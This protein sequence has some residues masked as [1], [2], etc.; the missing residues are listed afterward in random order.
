V[1]VEGEVYCWGRGEKGQLGYGGL[2][3]QHWPRRADL[4]AAA[5]ALEAG[6]QTACA[7]TQASRLLCWGSP[8]S[9]LP[10]QPVR[11]DSLYPQ[12][13][14]VL[15]DRQLLLPVVGGG[16]MCGADGDNL[17]WCIGVRPSLAGGSIHVDTIPDPH[18]W[19]SDPDMTEVSFGLYHDC[20]V[21]RGGA[22]WCTGDNVYGQ[23]GTGRLGS[24]EE[25]PS[26]PV[27]G[28]LTFSHVTTGYYHT[29]GLGGT[30]VYCWGFN[31]EGQLGLG[32][33]EWS[34]APAAVAGDLRFSTL[35]AGAVHT[36]GVAEGIVY[37]WG[38]NTYGQLGDG[39]RAQRGGPV[40][41]ATGLRFR[42]ISSGFDH[43]CAVS[44]DNAIYCW[45]E[46]ESGQLGD[47]STS[48]ALSPVRVADRR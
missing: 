25:G 38:N 6:Q 39:T 23:L 18:V 28:G 26:A 47:G 48:D 16:R 14:L 42:S 31:A 27:V 21:D 11:P 19:L 36:C 15:G 3:D 12:P 7:V 1:S 9:H 13:A 44:V 4:P 20:H 46:N 24:G 41:V 32:N 45:G 30:T 17:V 10:D 43:T 35:D 8:Y 29:C 34:V 40:P 2:R 37:C 5:V 33:D 22:A